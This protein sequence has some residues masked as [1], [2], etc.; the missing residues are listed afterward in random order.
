MKCLVNQIAAVLKCLKIIFF[1]ARDKVGDAVKRVFVVKFADDGRAEFVIDVVFKKVF[2]AAFYFC[3]VVIFYADGHAVIFRAVFNVHRDVVHRPFF[4]RADQHIGVRAVGVE[5]YLVRKRL[6]LF[7]KVDKVGVER[8]LAAGDTNAFQNALSLF[9]I[10]EYFVFGN[11]GLSHRIFDKTRVVTKRTTEIAP[12]RKKRAC[13]KPRIVQERQFVKPV[14]NH[15]SLP[16]FV[17]DRITDIYYKY[18]PS[19]RFFKA[20]YNK[21]K[22]AR[23]MKNR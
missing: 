13:G 3:G 15:S 10:R 22:R 4:D 9:K 11:D 18:T 14:N 21:N 1:R 19:A 17:C 2:H 8:R 7:H 6:Y 5:F 20:K 23:S 16:F 12:A